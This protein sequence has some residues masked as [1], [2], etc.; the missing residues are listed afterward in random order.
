MRFFHSARFSP[1][2]RPGGEPPPTPS[3]STACKPERRKWSRDSPR[4]SVISSHDL[5]CTG[6]P[7]RHAGCVR[8]YPGEHLCG[9]RV[10]NSWLLTDG[11]LVAAAYHVAR[12]C[13]SRTTCA[14]ELPRRLAP[15]VSLPPHR[16]LSG[17]ARAPMRSR[18]ATH[19]AKTA[20]P[21]DPAPPLD[22]RS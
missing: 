3:S 21:V 1:E 15:S 8:H 19:P 22:A 7:S 2:C 9:H 11:I 4:P 14:L 20:G 13:R 17:D 12:R 6:V 5:R 16:I 18:A 10:A